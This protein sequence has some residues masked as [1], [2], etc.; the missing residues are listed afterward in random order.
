M[1]ISVSP[2]GKIVSQDQT[3]VSVSVTC[4]PF[5]TQTGGSVTV[6]LTQQSGSKT[7]TGSGSVPITCDG[8]SHNYAVLVTA[9]EGRW[10]NGAAIATATGTATGWHLT[11]ACSTSNGM[12]V[13]TI[14]TAPAA[15]TGSIGPAT[16]SLHTD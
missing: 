8:Q 14:D 13:C 9:G 7:A 16:V 4:A 3:D 15:D 5:A 1:T 12:T 11:E 2:G 6:S 10:H